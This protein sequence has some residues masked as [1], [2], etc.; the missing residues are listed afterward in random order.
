[1]FGNLFLF[2]IFWQGLMLAR[3]ALYYGA[4]HPTGNLYVKIN[5]EEPGMVA[6]ICNLNYLG[7]GGRKI[8]VQDWPQ[9]KHQT[10]LKGKVEKNRA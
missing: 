7:S 2:L 3:K 8:Q 4:K 6:H 9:Q 10:Y 1:M 5:K